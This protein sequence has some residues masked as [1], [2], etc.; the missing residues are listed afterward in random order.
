MFRGRWQS[1][2]SARRYIQ[3]GRALLAAQQVPSSVNRLGILFDDEL[4][5]V[6][7]F[8]MDSVPLVLPSRRRV[9]FAHSS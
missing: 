4:T 1:M 6:L 9:Q 5:A 8:L 2:Q 7:G 3:S